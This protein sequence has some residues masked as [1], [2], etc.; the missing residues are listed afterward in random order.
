M[1]IFHVFFV[2]LPEGMPNMTHSPP[3]TGSTSHPSASPGTG[4]G[5]QWD[6]HILRIAVF[7][8]PFRGIKRMGYPTHMVIQ[9]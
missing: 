4:P 5:M 3:S 9:W 8:G 6:P 2:C 7:V 1:V